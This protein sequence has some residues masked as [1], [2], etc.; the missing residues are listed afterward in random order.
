MRVHDPALRFVLALAALAS[1]IGPALAQ[2]DEATRAVRII[3]GAPGQTPAPETPGTLVAP[4]SPPP[5]ATLDIRQIAIRAENDAGLELS[6]LPDVELAAGTKVT[7]RVATRKQGYL[8]LVDVDPT[9][10]LTQVYPNRHMLERRDNQESLNLIKAGQAI[11]IPNRDNPYA[12]FEFVASPPAGIAM[13]VAILSDRPVHLLDLPD[14]TP[15]GSG[16]ASFDQLSEVARRLRIAREDGSIA[17]D[18][19]RWSF[20][21]KLYL[22]K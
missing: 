16:Q 18:G 15:P 4:T 10:K 6:I 14:V 8:I 9:G 20:D 17:P 12:G 1:L 19:P 21:A 5:V 3:E 13:L 22:V 11:M 2:D 7:V